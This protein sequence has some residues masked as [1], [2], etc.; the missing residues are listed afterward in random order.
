MSCKIVIEQMSFIT[1]FL[2][3]EIE[4]YILSHKGIE[5]MMGIKNEG[6]F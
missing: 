4:N 6:K 1:V 5:T 3:L 2:L